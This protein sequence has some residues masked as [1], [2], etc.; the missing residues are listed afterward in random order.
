MR[1]III[2]KKGRV[3]FM[4]GPPNYGASLI[5]TEPN[6]KEDLPV[7]EYIVRNVEDKVWNEWKKGKTNVKQIKKEIKSS[8]N[9]L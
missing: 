2:S 7:E 6:G 3:T 9:K 8:Q 1:K 5:I 4:E